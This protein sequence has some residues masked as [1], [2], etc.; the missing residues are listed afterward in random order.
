MD[1]TN[2]DVLIEKLGRLIES[3]D[4]YI[5]GLSNQP[6]SVIDVVTLIAAVAAVLVSA[7]SIYVTYR[8]S[9]KGRK[10]NE[11]IASQM[12][13]EENK[14]AAAEINANLT[15][16]ARIEWIQNVRRA[17][18]DLL[19]ACYRYIESESPA[20]S[21]NW[22]AV[23]EKKALF[24]LYFGPDDDDSNEKKA[25]GLFD[26]T[27]NKGKNNNIV[28]FVNKLYTNMK[29]YHSNHSYIESTKKEISKCNDCEVYDEETNTI[30][31]NYRC[32]KDEYF[33]PFDEDDCKAEKEKKKNTLDEYVSFE[34]GVQDDIQ[35]LSEIMRIYGKIEWNRAKTT[36]NLIN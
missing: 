6:I 3:L 14:R 20:Q 4:T 5:S 18:A 29:S 33:T 21:M 11:K 16:N 34:K 32:I 8:Y 35:I 28:S 23:Q 1:S 24:V 2:I 26:E 36:S 19:A 10:S 22:Q 15:A 30:Y 13:S 12:Q 7:I 25:N 9:E 17:T 31:M 27:T